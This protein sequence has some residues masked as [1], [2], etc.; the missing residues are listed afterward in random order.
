M[1]VAVPIVQ[2]ILDWGN[3]TIDR[4]R[5]WL[6]GFSEGAA[7]AVIAALAYPDIFQLALGSSFNTRPNYTHA[8]LHGE[9]RLREDPSRKRRLKAF[10]I[11]KGETDEWPMCTT[12]E[13]M[14]I[15]ASTLDNEL[16]DH[17]SIE[18]RYYKDQGHW[19]WF[20]DWAMVKTHYDALWK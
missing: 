14:D 16:F 9:E 7:G 1:D 2:H 19:T 6:T 8:A 13:Q 4:E 10:I 17:Y 20:Q 12:P 3:G 11:S 15:W 18:T 5:I